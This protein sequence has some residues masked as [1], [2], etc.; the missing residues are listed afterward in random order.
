MLSACAL[1]RI[2]C[3]C[4]RMT[5]L[6]DLL[7][8][9]GYPV[10]A[11]D[12]LQALADVLPLRAEVADDLSTTDRAYLEEFSGLE[13]A[14]DEEVARLLARRAALATAEVARALDR[15]EVGERLGISPSRV[16]HRLAA[17]E[18]FAFRIGPAKT[19]YPDWQFTARGTLPG[20]HEVVEALP[21][22][23]PAALVRRFMTDPDDA[24]E[25][26]DD[27]VAPREWLL[28]GGDVSRVVELAT[29]LG[30]GV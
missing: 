17:G 24:L 13:R 18:L 21:G 5:E 12:V 14:S 27:P 2:P 6:P 7:E 28:Q 22:G 8:R 29:T 1:E 9:T 4:V 20:L 10:S 15:T 19:L 11:E 23:V 3:D 25:I 30:D 16:S 26:G